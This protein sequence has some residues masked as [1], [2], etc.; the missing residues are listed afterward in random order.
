[1]TNWPAPERTPF[2]VLHSDFVSHYGLEIRHL[3]ASGAGVGC[4]VLS[5]FE[6]APTVFRI[7]MPARFRRQTVWNASGGSLLFWSPD[8][9]RA[10]PDP[11]S[12]QSVTRTASGRP[13]RFGAIFKE[14]CALLLRPD[15]SPHS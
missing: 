2:G 14:F 3:P 12:N 9:F 7:E 15:G 6:G 8:P 11:T 10:E 1:M 4:P 13:S 5:L